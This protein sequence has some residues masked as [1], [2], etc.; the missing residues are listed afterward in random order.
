MHAYTFGRLGNRT[1]RLNVALWVLQI[2]AGMF[3]MVGFLKLLGSEQLA[4]LFEAI[5]VGQRFR[6]LTGS[7]E[8]AGAILLLIP[9]TGGLGALLLAGVMAGAVITH[10]FVVG[11]NP[12][13]AIILLGVTSLIAWERRPQ[14]MNL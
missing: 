3:L 13:M 4:G 11:G 9:R 8:V 14:T 7:L 5:G 6:Y 2:A 10:L 1:S 12:L